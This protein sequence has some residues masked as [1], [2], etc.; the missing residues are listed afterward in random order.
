VQYVRGNFWGRESSPDLETAQERVAAWCA[1]RAGLRIH[2]S[3]ATR[4]AELFAEAERDLLLTVPA[5]YDVPTF[6][7]VKVGRDFHVE[8]ARALYSV[9][10]HL[11]GQYLDARA[12]SELVTLS[13]RG[14][15]L[16]THPRQ[17]ARRAART[18]ESDL[19]AERAGYAH[20]GT[21]RS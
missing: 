21:S 19:P 3:T 14:V 8:V 12:D 10:A 17:R 16:K 13:G 1:V 2:G 5:L 7:R 15:I 9:P 4:P 20:A 6:T 18:H 11:L